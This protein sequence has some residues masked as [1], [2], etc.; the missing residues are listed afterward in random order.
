MSPEDQVRIVVAVE[1]NA[2][3]HKSVLI[4][5]DI[6]NVDAL[7]LELGRLYERLGLNVISISKIV[8]AEIAL[9]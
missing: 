6:G 3:E 1:H 4:A 9:A 7:A 8:S 5:P 2:K